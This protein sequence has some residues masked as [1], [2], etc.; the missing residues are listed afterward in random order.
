LSV[1]TASTAVTYIPAYLL[2]HEPIFQN[3]NRLFSFASPI[4]E[5]TSFM[6]SIQKFGVSAVNAVAE[7]NVSLLH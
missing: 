5:P 4:A 1:N 3:F 2:P 7:K 6:A